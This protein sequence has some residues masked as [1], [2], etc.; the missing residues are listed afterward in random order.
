MSSAAHASETALAQL[1]LVRLP[2]RR[3]PRVLLSGLGM[4]LTLRAAL[5]ALPPDA[6]VQVVELHP[7]V[8]AWCRGPLAE[9]NAGAALDP[10]VR[11]EPGDVADAIARAAAA[12]LDAILLDLFVGPMRPPASDPHYGRAALARARAALAPGGVL[13]LWAERPDAGFARRLA[14]AGFA[15]EVARPGRGGLRHAVYLAARAPDTPGGR[16][17]GSAARRRS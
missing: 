9:L 17:R 14:A 1:A 13:A 12:S 6:R 3:A 5:D 8:V 15:V 10:R 2:R 4:G 16:S 7:V 11:V